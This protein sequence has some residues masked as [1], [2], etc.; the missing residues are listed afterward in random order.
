[1][2]RRI[3]LALVFAQFVLLVTLAVVLGGYVLATAVGDT[4]G[5]MVLWWI[6]MACLMLVVMD[7]LLLAGVLGIAAIVRI[8]PEKQDSSDSA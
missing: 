8:E 6:A 2:L 3:L 1:M 5:P 4:L 7:V